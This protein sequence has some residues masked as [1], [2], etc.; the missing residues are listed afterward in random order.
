MALDDKEA[1]EKLLFT[2]TKNKRKRKKHRPDDAVRTS[3][4]SVYF[5]EATWRYIPEG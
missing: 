2:Q 5:R 4:M 3:E 1:R